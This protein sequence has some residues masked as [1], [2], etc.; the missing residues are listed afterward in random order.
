VGR[1]IRRGERVANQ[2]R[3]LARFYA[4]VPAGTVGTVVKT[5]NDPTGCVWCKLHFGVNLSGQ[6]LVGVFPE[7]VLVEVPNAELTGAGGFIA[8][9]RVERRVR[10]D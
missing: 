4:D 5:W 2:Q 3:A 8:C 9:V 6:K 7:N 10:G 1:H